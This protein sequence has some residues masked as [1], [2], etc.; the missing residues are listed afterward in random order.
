VIRE[1]KI[2][3]KEATSLITISIVSRIFFT[4]PGLLAKNL[5]TAAWYMTLI[6]ALFGAIG[7]TFVCLLLKKYPGKDLIEVF[8]AVFGRYIALFFLILL[9]FMFIINASLIVREFAEVMKAYIFPLSPITYVI[10]ILMLFVTIVCILGFE[11]ISRFSAFISIVLLIVFGIVLALASGSYEFHRLA[12]MLGYGLGKTVI[13]GMLRCGVYADPIILAVL[14]GSMQ[15]LGHIKKAGYLSIA[16]SAILGSLSF[17]AFTMT[18]PYFSAAEITS[19]MY[20]MVTLIDYGRFVQRTE[21]IFLFLWNITT[22]VAVAINLY[23]GASVYCKTFRIQD[24]RPVIIP[25]AI[26]TFTIAMLPKDVSELTAVYIQTLRQYGWAGYFIP[27][28]IALFIS[29][30]RKKEDKISNA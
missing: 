16:I 18:F 24:T 21:A 10:G 1:G 6:S 30:F 22:F 19:P 12:P 9:T 3:V 2:G 26:L 29:I 5:G 14:A 8:E 20:Q 25:L 7:F 4:S 11:S 17:L 28:V 27:P 23:A 15:G 13:T